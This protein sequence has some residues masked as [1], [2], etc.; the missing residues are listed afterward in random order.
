MLVGKLARTIIVRHV[1]REFQQS[2][3]PTYRVNE[4]IRHCEVLTKATRPDN[5]DAKKILYRFTSGEKDSHN[6]SREY[7]DGGLARC[8]NHATFLHDR[9]VSLFYRRR[10]APGPRPAHHKPHR[11]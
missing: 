7:A 9:F 5:R 1:H 6:R 10:K 3:Y 8:R 11:S 2:G 4:L